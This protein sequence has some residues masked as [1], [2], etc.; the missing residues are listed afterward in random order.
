MWL[1]DT[2]AGV[3]AIA[4]PALRDN[5]VGAPPR[6]GPTREL[7]DEYAGAHGNAPVAE[8]SEYR[9]YLARALQSA[10]ILATTISSSRGVSWSGYL[11]AARDHCCVDGCPLLRHRFG[12]IAAILLVWC[13]STCMHS[14]ATYIPVSR[15]F[16]LKRSGTRSC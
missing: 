4:I 12:A 14:G 9:H 10:S 5:G 13:L 16:P 2:R 11:L 8:T 3:P 7:P 15:L 6:W 1:E